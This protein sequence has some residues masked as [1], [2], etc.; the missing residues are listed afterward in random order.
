MFYVL[1]QVSSLTSSKRSK[2][3]TINRHFTWR[4][5]RISTLQSEGDAFPVGNL[6]PWESSHH[7]RSSNVLEFPH[8]EFPP[9]ERPRIFMLW[10]WFR[11]IL[12]S[13]IRCNGIF[14]LFIYSGSCMLTSY[15][16][17]IPVTSYNFLL[18]FYICFVHISILF[19]CNHSLLLQF[20]RCNFE[21][22]LKCNFI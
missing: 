8:E 2:P 13:N 17:Q 5:A 16:L 6:Q 4:P 10:V 20:F 12:E 1:R 18:W 7:L 22:F 21:R 9:T 3:D 15:P 11:H 19:F 14:H